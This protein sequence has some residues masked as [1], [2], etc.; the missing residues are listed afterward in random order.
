[1]R[2]AA[3]GAALSLGGAA[4]LPAQSL[5]LSASRWLTTP[6][7]TDYR[8][9]LLARQAGP[10]S[11][12]PFGQLTLQGP[13][14]EDGASFLGGGIDLALRIDRR[15]RP[16]LIGGVSA[17]FLDLRRTAGL[18][19][20]HAWSV[21]AG[22]EVTRIGPLGAAVELRRQALSR[23]GTG[24][25]SLG[26]R[27]GAALGADQADQ[28]VAIA[29]A[30]MATP[31]RW[32]GSDTEGFDCSGLIQYAYRELGIELPRRSRDQAVVGR[33]VPTVVDSLA[34]GDILVFAGEPGGQASH[35]GLYGGDGRFIHSASGGVRESAL[36]ADDWTGRWWLERWIGARRVVE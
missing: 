22:V 29:R 12:V 8:I 14:G 36:R 6:H 11:L 2:S 15:A 13:R 28:I 1:M 30:A 21:G 35:V 23:G 20:W 7:V 34:P 27:L 33:P 31:Y 26:V 32:G 19:L 17:G 5:S 16:Y 25:L 10:L 24:G 3:I 9:S 4:G 18:G